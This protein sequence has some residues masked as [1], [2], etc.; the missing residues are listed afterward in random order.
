M[1][2]MLFVFL[3]NLIIKIAQKKAQS[4]KRGHFFG[5]IKLVTNQTLKVALIIYRLSHYE[6]KKIGL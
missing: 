5:E 6:C 4:I 1:I 2:F 3:G